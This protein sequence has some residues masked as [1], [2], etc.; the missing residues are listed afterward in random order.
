LLKYQ[1]LLF[2]ESLQSTTR[3]STAPSTNSM[4]HLAIPLTCIIYGCVSI[5]HDEPVLS[6]VVAQLFKN[7]LS[8][9][10]TQSVLV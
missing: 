10:M 2:S 6:K 5:F 9:A 8:A 1:G 3:A 4:Y 7:P